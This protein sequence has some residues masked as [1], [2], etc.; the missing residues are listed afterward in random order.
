MKAIKQFLQSAIIIFLA[1]VAYLFGVYVTEYKAIKE[2]QKS[3]VTTIAVVKADSGVTVDGEY[4]NYASKLMNYPML[5]D[6]PESNE[7]VG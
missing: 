6:F 1:C 3:T 4:I 5:G 2:G 7:Y